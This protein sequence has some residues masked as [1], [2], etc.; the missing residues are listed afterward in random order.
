[1]DFIKPVDYNLFAWRKKKGLGSEKMSSSRMDLGKGRANGKR[2]AQVSGRKG[3]MK[4]K[5]GPENA[6]CTYKGMRERK[7]GK[8]VAKISDP[9][10][11][12]RLWLGTFKTSLEAA[13]A[14]DE[15]ALRLYGAE[16]RF[17][18]PELAASTSLPPSGSFPVRQPEVVAVE[19]ETLVCPENAVN[20]VSMLCDNNFD[21]SYEKFE[22][23]NNNGFP[24]DLKASFPEFG[25]P[26]I[27]EEAVA[28]IDFPD[29]TDPGISDNFED[30]NIW[31]VVEYPWG[32]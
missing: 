12:P 8:W 29:V 5:G 10:G 9:S 4:G 27:W 18:L 1:M 32:Y 20:T 30:E 31:E 21:P 2:F 7:W 19:N 25:D 22:E 16:A 3:C 14:Y 11:G 24:E 28:T 6:S 15:A 17:N 23:I 26:S 13:K